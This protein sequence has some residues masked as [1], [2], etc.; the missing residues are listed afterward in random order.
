MKETFVDIDNK[1]GLPNFP[2]YSYYAE[3]QSVVP[4]INKNGL[5]K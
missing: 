5:S 4:A 1:L 2:G 3:D